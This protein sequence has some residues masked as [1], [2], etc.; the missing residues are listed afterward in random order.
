MFKI[1][2]IFIKNIANIQNI[3]YLCIIKIIK[4][5]EKDLVICFTLLLEDGSVEFLTVSIYKEGFPSVDEVRK[6]CIGANQYCLYSSPIQYFIY[7]TFWF[8]LGL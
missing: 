2:K 1:F 8:D 7:K 6:L 5:M 3:Y 4:D